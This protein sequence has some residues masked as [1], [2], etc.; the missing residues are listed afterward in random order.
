MSGAMFIGQL[1]CPCKVAC[2]CFVDGKHTAFTSVFDAIATTNTTKVA[3]VRA[4]KV[5]YEVVRAFLTMDELRFA[6]H[7]FTLIT[8]ASWC[9]KCQNRCEHARIRK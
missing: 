4:M 8:A 6:L 1:D 3:Y 9:P 7:R 5:A 2:S